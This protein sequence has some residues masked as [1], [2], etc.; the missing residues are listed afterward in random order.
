MKKFF[1]RFSL[2]TKF[3]AVVFQSVMIY[4]LILVNLPEKVN[5]IEWAVS[6]TICVLWLAFGVLYG[7]ME[8]DDDEILTGN[9]DM[10]ALNL[11]AILMYTLDAIFSYLHSVK[12]KNSLLLFNKAIN[13]YFGYDK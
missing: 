9:N 8:I 11:G 7:M 10:L 3:W 6:V 2:A 12:F 5:V 13:K 4:C 1:G